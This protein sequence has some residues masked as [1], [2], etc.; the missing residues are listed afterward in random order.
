LSWAELR[1][2]ER[3]ATMV[4]MIRDVFFMSGVLGLDPTLAG[5]KIAME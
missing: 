5:I 2:T 1:L 3:L 4:R